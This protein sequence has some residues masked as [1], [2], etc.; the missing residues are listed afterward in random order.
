MKGWAKVKS[1]A[2]YADVGERT[3]R[4]WL[5]NGLRHVRVRNTI[6]MR[7]EWIDDFLESFAIDDNEVDRIVSDVCKG[8]GIE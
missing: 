6:R 3:L 1:A 8:I 2:A 4:E 5:K 7:Y